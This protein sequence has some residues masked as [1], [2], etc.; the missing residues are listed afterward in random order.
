MT[1]AIKM[2]VELRPKDVQSP[3]LKGQSDNQEDRSVFEK[4]K[5]SDYRNRVYHSLSF[6]VSTFVLVSRPGVFE[7]DLN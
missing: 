3:C 7:C 2:S 1:S 4:L 5:D 6:A